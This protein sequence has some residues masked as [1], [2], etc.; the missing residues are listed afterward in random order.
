MVVGALRCWGCCCVVV[1]GGESKI[2]EMWALEVHEADS[3]ITQPTDLTSAPAM[4]PTK[5]LRRKLSAPSMFSQT[6]EGKEKT[7]EE[8]DGNAPSL[9]AVAAPKYGAICFTQSSPVTPEETS[10]DPTAAA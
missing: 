5:A 6:A 8:S 2:L 10:D 4:S 7:V 3:S 1:A 9:A